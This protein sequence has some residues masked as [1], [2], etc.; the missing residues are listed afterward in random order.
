MLN[1]T[2]PKFISI[3]YEGRLGNNMFQYASL[4][5]I[6]QRNNLVAVDIGDNP[7]SRVFKI[8]A[9]SRIAML[10]R[11]IPLRRTYGEKRGCTFEYQVFN[12]GASENVM[13]YGYFQSWK[14]FADQNTTD[15][16]K[17][18]DFQFHDDLRMR[19]TVQLIRIISPKVRNYEGKVTFIA[20]HIRRGDMVH[21]DDYVKYGYTTPNITYLNRAMTKFR[22]LYNNCL[23]ILASDDLD[24]CYQNIKNDDVVFIPKGNPPELDMAIL[25][26][27]NHTLMTV[28]SYGW[29]VA[30]LVGG[31]TIYYS[32]YPTPNSK[33]AE[34][35]NSAD[36][37]PES[38]IGM[39]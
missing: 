11:N 16:L 14:Y 9:T 33:L 27:C 23:F 15:R 37:R 30:W 12:L 26:Q 18:Q 4:L 29:W 22:F 7:L 25:A 1:S 39:M 28:G 17:H 10:N 5:G 38:W 8:K 13:L 31:T 35:F 32:G 2:G 36:Y 24:W 6:A 21:R 20:V 34:L 3:G 19:A